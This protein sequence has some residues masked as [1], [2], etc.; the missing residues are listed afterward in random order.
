LGCVTFKDAWG[1]SYVEG[2]VIIKG[3]GMI[4]SKQVVILMLFE[5]TNLHLHLFSFAMPPTTHSMKGSYMK[6]EFKVEVLECIIDVIE[7]T[8]LIN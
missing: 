4:G 5:M 2:D 8:R 6:Y 3:F 7:A 1:N